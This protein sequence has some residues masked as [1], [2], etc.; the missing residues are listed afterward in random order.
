[1][2]T[3]DF[4]N[5]SLAGIRVNAEGC[6]METSKRETEN[7]SAG[8]KTDGDCNETSK[9]KV[10]EEARK[11]K[12][13]ADAEARGQAEA[14][15][16]RVAGEAGAVADAIDAAASNLDDQDREG[17]ARYA[18][19]M[20]STLANVAGQIEGR[21]VD[22]LAT[23]AKRLARDNPALFMLGSV[24]VGF[25]LSRFFKASAGHGSNDDSASNDDNTSPVPP[26]EQRERDRSAAEESSADQQTGDGSET[27]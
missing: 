24:A 26:R 13:E 20:S 7:R 9:Q 15:R 6:Q 16:N 5:L 11:A 23:D 19:E 4:R 14:G 27:P 1:M 17:L 12:R 3:V 25:G 8:S 2:N 18:R 22:E 21:S 10:E